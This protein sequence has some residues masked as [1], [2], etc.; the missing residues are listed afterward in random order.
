MV[1]DGQSGW[2]HQ[3]R[4]LNLFFKV[5]YDDERCLIRRA[6]YHLRY[7]IWCIAV[8]HVALSRF[9]RD[10]PELFCSDLKK[11]WAIKGYYKSIYLTLSGK[12]VSKDQ[13]VE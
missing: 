2:I 13:N 11:S 6:M 10:E 3:R 9:S 4:R 5:N 12:Q 1:C 8:L 7:V